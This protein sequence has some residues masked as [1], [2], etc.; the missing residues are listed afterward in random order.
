MKLNNHYQE[1]KKQKGKQEE[2]L[3][4]ILKFENENRS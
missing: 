1:R 2:K 3:K 4:M